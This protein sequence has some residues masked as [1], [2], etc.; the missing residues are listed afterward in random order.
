MGNI[1]NKEWSEQ[2][3]SA[4]TSINEENNCNK[5]NNN[6]NSTK[7]KK[8]PLISKSKIVGK[9]S[10]YTR[11]TNS[12]CNSTPVASKI[13]AA[14][15][16]PR[17]PSSDIVRTPIYYVSENDKKAAKQSSSSN[18]P[19]LV[20]DP[21]SPLFEYKRTPIHAN[22]K[23]ATTSATGQ[24]SDDDDSSNPNENSLDSSSLLMSD[25]SMQQVPDNALNASGQ[26]AGNINDSPVSHTQ[27]T[28]FKMATSNLPRHILQRKQVEKLNRN[29]KIVDGQ[30]NKENCLE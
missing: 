18:G 9:S 6:R 19:M 15:F 26:S 21:R 10:E 7:D 11:I 8:S 3:D 4:D 13:V 12:S 28:G 22:V 23:K 27:T 25:S 2:I 16:D 30:E 14:E 1:L 24:I 5:N 17:S 20:N 29:K